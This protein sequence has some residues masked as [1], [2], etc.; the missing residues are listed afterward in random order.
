MIRDSP[1]WYGT[2]NGWAAAAI[3]FPE[4]DPM[5]VNGV[6]IFSSEARAYL[7]AIWKDNIEVR[8]GN[9]EEGGIT[10]ESFDKVLTDYIAQ[11]IPLVFDVDSGVESWNYP[12]SGFTRTKTEDGAWTNVQIEMRYI[13]TVLL[14]AVDRLTPGSRRLLKVN[15]T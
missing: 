1:N 5:V 11:N 10:A 7:A 4:P 14:K 12:V 6:K 15:Y 2:C 8:L 3:Q 9:Y 13:D